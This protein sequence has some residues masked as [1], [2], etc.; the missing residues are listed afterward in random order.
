M[1]RKTLSQNR[2][3]DRKCGHICPVAPSQ[4]QSYSRQ[5]RTSQHPAN[6]AH[7]IRT[8]KMWGPQ[9]QIGSRIYETCN[10]S[11]KTRKYPKQTKSLWNASETQPSPQGSTSNIQKSKKKII[12]THSWAQNAKITPEPR[13]EYQNT[14][15]SH[16]KSRITK[17][18]TT[19]LIPTKP[20]QNDAKLCTQVPNNKTDISHISKLKSEHDRHKANPW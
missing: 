1:G 4:M 10:I 9:K 7:S 18:T 14:W 5:K 6:H 19:R 16:W 3:I 13:I 12:Q 20:T 8:F 11:P 2:P 17:V 15:N